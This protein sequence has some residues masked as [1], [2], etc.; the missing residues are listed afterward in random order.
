MSG[1]NHILQHPQH[2]DPV[3][4]RLVIDGVAAEGLAARPVVDLGLRLGEG[5]GAVLALPI[6]RSSAAILSGMATFADAG[7]E[8]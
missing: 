5:S 7:I 3:A 8:A 2:H 6:V 1:G 4:V